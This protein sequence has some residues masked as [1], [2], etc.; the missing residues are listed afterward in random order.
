MRLLIVN[1]NTSDGVT[2]RIAT[3]ARAVAQP[4]DRFTT[5]SATSAPAPDRHRRRQRRGV[6]TPLPRCAG[7]GDRR[8]RLCGGT[9]ARRIGGRLAILTFAPE[10]VPALQDT[11]RHHGMLGAAG[12]I[13][14]VEGP[15]RHHPSEAA[16]R[17]FPQLRDRCLAGASDG[18]DSV[19]LG[20]VRWP[21]WP[22]GSGLNVRCR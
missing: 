10:V 6:A 12:Q 18:A 19:I 3:A 7:P 16:D 20:A 17:L 1:P 15:F 13:V 11:A 8:S 5:V 14:A 2:A 9:A 4:G 22:G 21:G